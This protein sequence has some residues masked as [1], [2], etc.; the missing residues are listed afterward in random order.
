[1][2]KI[3]L[4]TQ[5]SPG[6]WPIVCKCRHNRQPCQTYPSGF[7]RMPFTTF[8]ATIAGPGFRFGCGSLGDITPTHHSENV[9]ETT[10][11]APHSFR[12]EAEAA[13]A[14]LGKAVLSSLIIN[15]GGTQCSEW[16]LYYLG[17]DVCDHILM[18]DCVS[19]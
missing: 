3:H 1:M 11:A 2:K 10:V 17:C 13:C 8:Q 15:Q 9:R 16:L 5:I 7:P 12:V 19:Y 14:M 4:L 18:G 6:H